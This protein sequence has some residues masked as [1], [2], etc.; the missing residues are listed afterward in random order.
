M[1]AGGRMVMR[2]LGWCGRGA[3]ALDRGDHVQGLAGRHDVVGAEDPGAEPGAHRGHR[4]RAC[5]PVV[6]ADAE[7]L[8]HEV[9]AGGRHQHRPAGRGELVKPPGD[10]ERVPGVLAEV[11]GRVDDDPV[12]RHPGRQRP[13]GQQQHPVE[14]VRRHVGEGRPVRPGAGQRRPDVRADQADAELGRDVGDLRVPGRPGVVEQVGAGLAGGPGGLVPPGVNADDQVGVGR[15]DPLDERDDPADLLRHRHLGT[16]FGGHAA[17]VE[18]IGALGHDHVHALQ[19]GAG[20]PGHARPVE[21]VGGAVDD[22]H[23]QRAL[24]RELPAAQPQRARRAPRP[25]F[26]PSLGHVVHDH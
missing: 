19:G 26:A 8:P 12:G 11:V 2:G 9:L 22:R 16:G 1:R 17:D 18:Q 15:P 25:G 10:L 14:R 6:D 21:R 7:G 5:Q 20:V 24:R 13:A 23:H 3:V 4:Q